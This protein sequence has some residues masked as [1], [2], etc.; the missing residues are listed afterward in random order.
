MGYAYHQYFQWMSQQKQS[1]KE[2]LK[3]FDPCVVQGAQIGAGWDLHPDF[4]LYHCP[5]DI[6]ETSQRKAG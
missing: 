3:Q 4:V 5:S 6:E 1:F 2:V